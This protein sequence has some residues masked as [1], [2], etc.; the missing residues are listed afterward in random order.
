MQILHQLAIINNTMATA[1][2][3][4]ITGVA[5]DLDKVSVD[6]SANTQS[7]EVSAYTHTRPPSSR[8]THMRHDRDMHVHRYKP[9]S[10]HTI[11]YHARSMCV[12]AGVCPN[13]G[14]D[15]A[16]LVTL[17]VGVRSCACAGLEHQDG[18]VND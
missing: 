3:N 5:G 8:T 7:V 2:D 1:L 17:A 18:H 10:M 16:Y 9:E 11:P 14:E 6:V 15:A 4:E 12:H 13:A